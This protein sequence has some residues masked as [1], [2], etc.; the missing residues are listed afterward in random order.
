MRTRVERDCKNSDEDIKLNISVYN[1]DIAYY[2][3]YNK[4]RV[5]YSVYNND[6]TENIKLFDLS[7]AKFRRWF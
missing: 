6:N 5:Y 2:T 7:K 4:D 1:N 3:V